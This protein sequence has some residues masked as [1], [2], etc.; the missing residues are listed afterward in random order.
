MKGTSSK[1]KNQMDTTKALD[2]F[3]SHTASIEIVFKGD[4]VRVYFPIQPVCRLLSKNARENL[5]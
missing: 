5:M 2:F 1:D 3:K 4:L